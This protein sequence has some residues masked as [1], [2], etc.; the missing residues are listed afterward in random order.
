MFPS[1]SILD[2]PV[3]LLRKSAS[4]ARNL[5][6]YFVFIRSTFDPYVSFFLTSVLVYVIPAHGAQFPYAFE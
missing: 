1:F 6:I 3:D 4:V 5:F 2:K